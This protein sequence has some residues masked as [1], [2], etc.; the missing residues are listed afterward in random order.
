MDLTFDSKKTNPLNLTPP[1]FTGKAE[2]IKAPVAP[3]VEGHGVV[4]ENKGVK[5]ICFLRRHR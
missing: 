5:P 4:E 3:W 2:K 1:A